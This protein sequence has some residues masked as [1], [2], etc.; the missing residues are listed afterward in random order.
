MA[1]S[2][3]NGIFVCGGKSWLIVNDSTFKEPP[4]F[5]ASCT[6]HQSCGATGAIT[7]ATIGV[8]MRTLFIAA[9]LTIAASASAHACEG[10]GRLA[11]ICKAPLF[12]Q[13][14]SCIDN[15]IPQWDPKGPVVS[16]MNVP[17]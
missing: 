11:S 12:K 15:A 9:A 10:E 7:P 13:Y 2:R 8:I 17:R 5:S 4:P 6:T 1:R 14:T 16:K 3:A